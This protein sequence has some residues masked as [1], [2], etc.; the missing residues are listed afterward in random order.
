MNVRVILQPF[1][2]EYWELAWET[3]Y[4]QSLYPR[5]LAE[6]QEVTLDEAQL[7]ALVGGIHG[8]DIVEPRKAAGK[9]FLVI[10][11]EAAKFGVG[12]SEY[13]LMRTAEIELERHRDFV[14]RNLPVEVLFKGRRR[15]RKQRNR[16]AWISDVAFWAQDERE[17][18]VLESLFRTPMSQA[19]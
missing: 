16:L 7:Q 8:F 4:E 3:L 10:E 18:L 17:R 2:R 11:L 1:A 9:P 6:S 5:S 19:A 15:T 13:A 12:T 14:L